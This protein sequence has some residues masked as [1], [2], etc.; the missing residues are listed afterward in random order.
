M[1]YSRLGLVLKAEHQYRADQH[2]D[3][4]DKE[5]RKEL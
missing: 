2:H 1:E 5:G 3:K 4:K